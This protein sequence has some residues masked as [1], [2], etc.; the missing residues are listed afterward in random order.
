MEENIWI[1][2]EERP[3]L[4]VIRNLLELYGNHRSLS[5]KKSREI[6]I[7]PIFRNNI[8]LNIYRIKN[9]SIENVSEVLLKI[10]SGIKSF[11]DY[12]IYEGSKYPP[13]PKDLKNVPVLVSEVTKTADIESRNT[14]IYQRATKFVYVDWY[15]PQSKK[16]MLYNLEV[17]ENK[18]P[19]DTNIFGSRL[20][21]TIGVEIIGKEY[22][23]EF[24]PFR[25]IDEIIE[26]KN[27]MRKPPR[28][29]V[30]I[31]IKKDN[32]VIYIS[33]R[34][35]KSDRL[36]H[37]P[38]IGALTLI[39][40]ALR[41]L[42]WDNRIVIT[43]HG[44]EQKHLSK[45]NKFVLISNLLNIE[46][47]GLNIPTV[48]LPEMYWKYEY[49]SEKLATILLHTLALYAKDII[50]IYENH[51]GCERGYLYNLKNEPIVVPKYINGEKAKGIISLPDLVLRD[52]ENKEIFSLEG[53]KSSKISEALRGLEKF[54]HFEKYLHNYYKNYELKRGIVLYGKKVEN[55]F[56]LF[57]L[58]QEG[59]VHIIKPSARF[60]NKI[61]EVIKLM[62]R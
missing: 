14:G 22:Y 49:N 32:N 56:I 60:L 35:I 62:N 3:K 31:S 23:G 51:A 34:L 45:R 44:L 17:K 8:F 48:D 40:K 27:K 26:M 12:L 20:L 30:P 37:D 39:S 50:A 46:L 57:I 54:K 41:K 5:F 7:L 55:K 38:N 36:A 24:P 58:T 43:H 21:V 1:L 33:G 15:Y 52:N 53:K 13:N 9:I 16:I 11:V 29:N 18:K 59:K 28:T 19:S 47:E 6:E 61:E 42:G 4:K 2:S 25:S 10:V